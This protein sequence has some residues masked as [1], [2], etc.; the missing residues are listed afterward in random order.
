MLTLR[1]FITDQVYFVKSI[2]VIA[3]LA[4]V[5]GAPLCAQVYKISGSVIQKEDI[6]ISFANLL[7]YQMVDTSFVKGAVSDESG[8]FLIEDL[9]PGPY[10]LLASYMGNSSEYAPLQLNSDLDIGPLFLDNKAQELKEVVIVSKKPTVEQKIDR[11]VFNIENTAL[12]ESNIWEVLKSTPGLFIMKDE[13]T[14]KGEGEVQILINGRKVSLPAADILNLLSGTSASSV[15][16][17]EVITAPPSKYDA[18]GSAMI[19]ISMKKNLITGYNGAV[20]NTYTQGV[21]PQY[22]L[23]TNHYFKGEKLETSFNYSYGTSK[24][25]TYYTDIIHFMENG[26]VTESWTSDL[27]DIGK[28]KRHNISMF[29]DYTPDAKN[30]ISFSSIT[31]FRPKYFGTDDS[32]TSINKTNDPNTTGFFTDNDSER[33]SL[34][35]LDYERKLNDKGATLNL[36]SHFTYYD[37]DRDQV[38]ETDFYDENGTVVDENDFSTTN[39]QQTRLYSLQADFSTPLGERSSFETGLKYAIT[40]SESFIA[41]QGFDRNQ[42]GIDPTEEGIFFYDEN[43]FAAYAS[44]DSKWKNWTFKSGLRAEYT[45]TIGDFSLDNNAVETDYI[46][47]FPTLY[48]QFEPDQNHHFGLNFRRSI[49]R[50]DY[51]DINPFQAFQ[52][53]NSVV[54]G[55]VDLRPS[56]KNSLIFNYTYNKDYTFE[57]F[58]R[59]HEN[60][61]TLFTFQDNSSKL[62]RFVTDNSDRELAYGLDFIY[63]KE[64]TKFW[65]TYLLSSYFYAAER[66][67]VPESL[68]MIDHGRWTL[69]LQFQNNFSLLSDRS[70]TANINFTYVS[71]IIVGNSRQEEYKLWDLSLKKNIWGKKATVSLAVSDIFNQ[72]RLHNTRNYDDQY[73]ISFYRPDS[74]MLTLGFRYNFGNMGIKNNYKSKGTDEDDR[75]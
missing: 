56:Y 33:V 44:F 2:A 37:Y 59:Y 70:L 17:I 1:I 14:V 7:L 25:I 66:F 4:L 58:Y 38:V 46:E 47:L 73:N 27:E 64:F 29:L 39:R 13:I 40:R 61:I 50:P 60:R 51:Y 6:G 74:R 34:N 69:F 5:S 48:L 55:N 36:N 3:I 65:D 19:N 21:F 12:S 45:K 72:F 43:I 31:A 16:A 10:L 57:L 71:P 28:G 20:Y 41:Q 49:M 26:A 22:M 53:N 11:L 52:S 68:E 24:D 8:F 32:K 23:G 67:K 9:A 30:T 54:E 18:E 63:S 75:L 42:P 15:Q 62:L 35:Y